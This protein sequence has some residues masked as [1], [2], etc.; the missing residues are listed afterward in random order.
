[1]RRAEI[2]PLELREAHYTRFF[3]PL[4]EAVMHSTDI[5]AVHIDIYQFRPKR[6]RKY[7]TLI[8]GGMSDQP[9]FVPR[10]SPKHVSRRVELM[11]YVRQP[12]PWM[13]SVMKGLAE[14]PFDDRIFLH[15]FHTVPNGMP[16]TAKP[17]LLT[18]FFFLPP[19][20]EEK[21]FDSLKLGRSKV[22]ILWLV[23]ITEAERVYAAKHGSERLEKL[24]EAREPEARCE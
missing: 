1:M 15:W 3:G 23:P 2:N 11:M 16:M 10:D 9:Q 14:M 6:G 8:T 17:S 22:D 12:A 19:Y 7:W 5:K 18:S 4:T 20:F 24:H 21:G 13:F